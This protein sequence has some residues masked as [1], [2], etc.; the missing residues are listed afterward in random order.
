VACYKQVGPTTQLKPQ[1]HDATPDL[2]TPLQ[3]FN[4]LAYGDKLK[5]LGSKLGFV[6]LH[7]NLCEVAVML[8]DPITYSLM[9]D[10]T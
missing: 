5:L 4:E 6:P 7:S 1:Q 8:K 9:V 3:L 2:K 10:S